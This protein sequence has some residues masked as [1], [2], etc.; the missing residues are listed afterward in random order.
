MQLNR[1]TIYAND[2]ERETMSTLNRILLVFAGVI[3]VGATACSSHYGEVTSIPLA[4]QNVELAPPPYIIRAGDQL[5]IK[6]FYNPELNDSIVVR[7]DGKISLQLVDE[8]Q[9]EDLTPAQLDASLTEKY[10]R[11]LKKPVVTVIVRSFTGQ[12]V[13]VGGEVN[14]QGLI[15][16]PSRLT[17]L[18]AVYHAGGLK[19]T[20]MPEHTIIIRKGKSNEP[21]PLRVNLRDV[22]AGKAPG[23]LYLQP[24]DIV[25][26]PRSQIAEANLFV[27]QYIENLLL[28]RGVSMGFGYQFNNNNN[29]NN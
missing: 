17:V 10:S 7:P 27:K 3:S 16:S 4:V 19:E 22:M 5:E 23:V 2:R 29:N 21:V 1:W 13:Y 26:V 28:F 12:G 15:S 8:I 6:F 14:Q 18:Q 9:A 25:Y 20:A 24:D 11:E